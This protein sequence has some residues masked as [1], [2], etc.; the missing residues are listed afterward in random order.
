MEALDLPSLH[1]S[2][3]EDSSVPPE[4]QRA[5]ASCFVASEMHVHAKGHTLPSTAAD[6]AVL[7]QFLQQQQLQLLQQQQQLQQQPPPPPT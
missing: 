1:I 5:L 4:L 7:A 2:G 3:A 6:I